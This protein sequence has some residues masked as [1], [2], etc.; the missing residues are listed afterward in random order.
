MKITNRLGV[1]EPLMTLANRDFYSKGRSA[2]SVTEVLMSPRIKHLRAQHDENIETDVSDMLWSMLGSALHVVAERGQT[3]GWSAE[4]RL[5]LNIGGTTISGQI[6][7]QQFVGDDVV[8]Y[9]Y[10]FT[11]AWAVM[12]N[13]VEWE[14][15]LN[16]YRHLVEKVKGR[17]VTGLKICAFIRDWSRH[18]SS[19]EGYPPAQ[20]TV[21]DVPMWDI[22]TA[23][24][25]L[26]ERL[27]LHQSTNT[28]YEGVLPQCSDQDRWMSETIYAVRKEGRKTAIRV[29][30][31]LNEATQLATEKQGYVEV[32]KGE[33]RRC[34]GNWCGVNQWC[35]QHRAYLAQAECERSHGEEA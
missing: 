30:K 23:E 8:I 17:K 22:E 16:L 27:H 28:D 32:R 5:F 13:K 34:T 6:D 7:L 1:P 18:E 33:P 15:Q 3:P 14:E 24:K 25:F 26:M 12:N 20:I 31:D 11:S 4:E 35:D 19:K 9:D 10:K 21:L 2:Y 29:F